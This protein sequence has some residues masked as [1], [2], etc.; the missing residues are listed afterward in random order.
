MFP[1]QRIFIIFGII[2]VM[3]GAGLWWILPD[4]PMK[5]RWL[6][7]R[8]RVIAV[9]RLK[10]NRTGVKSNKHKKE[11][12]VEALTDYRVW[13]LLFAV[14]C[15]NMT[16]S[17]LTNFTGIIIEGFGYSTYQ[18]VLLQI[19]VGAIMAVAMILCGF[20]LSSK[21]GEGRRRFTIICCYFPGIV[22]GGILYEVPVN[23]NTLGAHLAAIFLI[24]IV[25]TAGGLMYSLL[26][27]NIA[28]YTR[29]P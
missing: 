4:S 16:N 14:F 27:A 28:G 6:S 13:M 12:I 20:F 18:S 29:K 10:D 21:W 9:Q 3:V 7:D 19:P 5:C 24:P 22:A 8:E 2:T 26:A 17:L 11:Q 15:H 1:Y 25:A 23:S